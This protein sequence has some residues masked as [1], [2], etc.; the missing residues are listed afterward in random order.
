MLLHL[1]KLLLQG[2]VL[3]D[4][5]ALVGSCNFIVILGMR[6][7]PRFSLGVSCQ[8]IYLNSGGP[9]GFEWRCFWHGLACSFKILQ[10]SYFGFLFMDPSYS[11]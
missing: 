5:C 3:H 8:I 10:Q 11:G 7:V 2:G 9:I 1:L 6:S 4:C